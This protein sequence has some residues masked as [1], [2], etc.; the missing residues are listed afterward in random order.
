MFKLIKSY[1]EKR[2]KLREENLEKIERF[3]RTVVL[4]EKF[5]HVD[6]EMHISNC[7]KN[8]TFYMYNDDEVFFKVVK[9][10]IEN[11]SKIEKGIIHAGCYCN[12]DKIFSEYELN[13]LFPKI[14]YDS[15]TGKNDYESF[16]DRIK[17]DYESFNFI[18][19]NIKD[20][21]EILYLFDG[22]DYFTLY[23]YDRKIN[24]KENFAKTYDYIRNEDYLIAINVTTY[25]HVLQ[26]FYDEKFISKK[27]LEQKF[28]NMCDEFDL[29]LEHE[30]DLV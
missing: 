28:Q 30:D 17:R 5:E 24:K 8:L 6:E 1:M 29:I 23:V 27:E 16:F 3:Y 25:H 18:D 22:G 26:V 7:H 15:F 4:S 11:I 19:N 13:G 10:F 9:T 20:F 21:Y 12:E 2:K 14:V